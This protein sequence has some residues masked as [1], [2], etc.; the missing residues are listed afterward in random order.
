MSTRKKAAAAEAARLPFAPLDFVADFARQQLSVVN[1]ANGAMFRGFEA[2]REI[3]QQAAHDAAVRHEAAV[4]Q[5]RNPGAPVEFASLQSSL[6]QEDLQGAGRY[7]R[8][9]MGAALE[10]QVEMMG[11]A[12]H[13]LDS[14]AAIESV[15]ALEAFDAMP[16]MAALFG[17][18]QTQ[19]H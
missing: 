4:Q 12:S 19:A 18:K 10:M 13:L 9:L 16:G 6:L 15:S 2:M 8:D 5:L 1:E 17:L 3:Q 7:W 14:E 11:C